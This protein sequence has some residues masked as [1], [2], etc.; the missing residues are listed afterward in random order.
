MADDYFKRA[1]ELLDR[2]EAQ[3]PDVA[4]IEWAEALERFHACMTALGEAPGADYAT[5]RLLEAIRD[6]T[7][8]AMIVGAAANV[9]GTPIPHGY[10]DGP[11]LVVSNDPSEPEPQK[12]PR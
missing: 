5:N 1:R 9:L 4:P 12:P 6:R 3:G 7:Q 10:Y 11:T 8:H 2:L